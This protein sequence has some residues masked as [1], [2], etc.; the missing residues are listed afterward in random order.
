MSRSA[1]GPEESGFLRVESALEDLLDRAVLHAR[2]KEKSQ[3]LTS[4]N[5]E[6]RHGTFPSGEYERLIKKRQA[7]VFYATE[8]LRTIGEHIDRIIEGNIRDL[9][10][11]LRA[12]STD[13]ALTS[14]VLQQSRKCRA[15][16]RAF[17][18]D[19]AS[20]LLR[21][22]R[23]RFHHG[24]AMPAIPG[25]TTLSVETMFSSNIPDILDDWKLLGAPRRSCEE[26]LSRA[27]EPHA[28]LIG[29]TAVSHDEM[30][31][32]RQAVLCVLPLPSQYLIHFAL[33][34]RREALARLL[35]SFAENA[36][37]TGRSRLTFHDTGS[38]SELLGPLLWQYGFQGR[39]VGEDA[40]RF[41]VLEKRV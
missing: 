8:I 29:K 31:K 41:A 38:Q 6:I 4:A 40:D 26:K 15:E 24:N 22:A 11:L 5:P 34:Q 16:A 28:A 3:L 19:D 27:A 35:H 14:G 9:E 20:E 2:E 17:R 30:G 23:A 39:M 13:A 12:G 18:A 7:G 32:E 21:Q 25:D 10:R 33:T 36:R 37:Q 1:S